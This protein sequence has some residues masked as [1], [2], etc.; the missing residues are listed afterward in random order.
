MDFDDDWATLKG[1]P[2]PPPLKDTLGYLV[3]CDENREWS[4]HFRSLTYTGEGLR[5]V[6]EQGKPKSDE[7][8]TGGSRMGRVRG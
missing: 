3:L 1:P 5:A 6:Y 7:N 8:A 2:R 4:E